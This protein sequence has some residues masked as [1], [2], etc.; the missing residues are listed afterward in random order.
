MAQIESERLD[1]LHAIIRIARRKARIPIPPNI[2]DT[3]KT[4]YRELHAAHFGGLFW[5]SGERPPI[6][7]LGCGTGIWAVEM[8][9]Y[10]YGRVLRNM[11]NHRR[12]DKE[13][14]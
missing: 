10:V 7:D 4:N 6:L 14:S 1:L 11:A 9:R 3:N 2:I 13:V 12:C 8:A 5:A